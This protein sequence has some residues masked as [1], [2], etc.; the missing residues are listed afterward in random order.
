MTV[1]RRAICGLEVP[2]AI[3]SY[4]GS[5]FVGRGGHKRQTGAWTPTLLENELL[6]I[7]MGLINSRPSRP[8]TNGKLERFHKS[9]EDEI[10]NYSGLDDYVEYYNT[11]RLHFSRDTG[12]TRRQ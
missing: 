4:S 10:R 1:L 5:C 6:G 12:T 7:N 2:A 11:D 8:Q 9:F 3:R